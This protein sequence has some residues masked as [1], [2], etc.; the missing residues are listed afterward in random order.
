MLSTLA[1][2]SL[3]LHHHLDHYIERV[4]RTAEVFPFGFSS[5]D[6]LPI[7]PIIPISLRLRLIAQLFALSRGVLDGP[8]MAAELLCDTS[9]V[10][11]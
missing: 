2:L 8:L 1:Q 9:L 6:I 7:S 5:R 4:S 11:Q 10:I 3:R